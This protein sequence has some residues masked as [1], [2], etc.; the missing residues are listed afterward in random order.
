MGEV[1]AQA[2]H[3]HSAYL[4]IPSKGE[5]D[6]IGLG[7]WHQFAVGYHLTNST[8]PGDLALFSFFLGTALMPMMLSADK[9]VLC[10]HFA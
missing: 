9:A 4:Q 10:E 3:F 7:T 1:K 5:K 2:F 8:C 6:E